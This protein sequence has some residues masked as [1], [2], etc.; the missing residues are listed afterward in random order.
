[1]LAVSSVSFAQSNDK[2]VIQIG[3]GYGGLIGGGT[4]SYSDG[5]GSYKMVGLRGNYGIRAQYGVAKNI[6]VGV[7]L[8]GEGAAYT[9]TNTNFSGYTITNS[10]A[11]F[12]VEG[13]YYIVNKDK[14]N[15]YGA[16]S[17]GFST[18]QTHYVDANYTSSKFNMSGLNYGVGLGINWYWAKF[19][20]MSAD[21]GYSGVSLSGKDNVLN[22]GT[23]YTD[24]FSSGGVYFGIG[25]ITKF[26]GN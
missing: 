14:F 26:G 4:M 20:G 21:L 9:S 16:P 8:R 12:G 25:L 1:M 24:K 5:I 3:V 6:S 18:G 13:K 22:P 15:F 7:F 17:I 10:G 2:G 23:T 19:I 11:A